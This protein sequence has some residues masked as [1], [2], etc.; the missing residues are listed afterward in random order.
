MNWIGSFPSF[1]DLNMN[2][3]AYSKKWESKY[4][5]RTILMCICWRNKRSSTHFDWIM[6]RLKNRLHR[7]IRVVFIFK[8]PWKLLTDF[9]CWSTSLTQFNKWP[10]LTLIARWLQV[11][12]IVSLFKDNDILWFNYIWF[13]FI[14]RIGICFRLSFDWCWANERQRKRFQKDTIELQT[15]FYQL[16]KRNIDQIIT[17]RVDFSHIYWSFYFNSKF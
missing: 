2:T 10:K 11:Y 6:S 7:S 16:K 13:M 1:L 3:N 12:K 17:Y 4:C 14:L 8:I 9:D 5:T 15:Q